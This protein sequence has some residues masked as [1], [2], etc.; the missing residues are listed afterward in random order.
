MPA[1]WRSY[2][3]EEE[4]CDAC[5]DLEELGPGAD[6]ERRD[7]SPRELV[8]AHMEWLIAGAAPDAPRRDS[9]EFDA[10][11]L[12]AVGIFA[13]RVGRVGERRYGLGSRP[14]SRARVLRRARRAGRERKRVF[15]W[16]GRDAPRGAAAAA[17]YKAVELNRYLGGGGG[18]PRAAR[19]EVEG[20]E[21]P[22]FAEA[23]DALGRVVTESD[24]DESDGGDADAPP[25]RL[26]SAEATRAGPRLVDVEPR[27][28]LGAAAAAAAARYY[29]SLYDHGPEPPPPPKRSWFGW[30]ERKRARSGDFGHFADDADGEP[31]KL[32]RVRWLRGGLDV[33]EARGAPKRRD[34]RSDGAAVLLCGAAV[35][36]AAASRAPR[37]AAASRLARELAEDGAVRLQDGVAEGREPLPF[38]SQ[39]ADCLPRTSSLRPSGSRCDIFSVVGGGDGVGVEVETFEQFRERRREKRRRRFEDVRSMLAQSWRIDEA[40]PTAR[41]ASPS[42][43]RG[44]DW[45]E[46]ADAFAVDDAEHHVVV[47]EIDGKRL[48]R[49]DEAMHGHFDAAK[50]YAVLYGAAVDVEAHDARAPPRRAAATAATEPG[51]R[52]RGAL[53]AADGDGESSDGSES[54]SS[55]DLV[56]RRSLRL[57]RSSLRRTPTGATAAGCRF[58]LFFWRG[59]RAPVEDRTRYLMEHR[60]WILEDWREELACAPPPHESH[61]DMREEPRAFLDVVARS[62]GGYVV[63]M[64]GGAD[65]PAHLFQVRGY[66]D[67]GDAV[68]F[69][70]EPAAAL[71]CSADCFA[72][73]AA[74]GSKA[75]FSMA[76]SG[77]ATWSL[78]KAQ[79]TM[80][81]WVGDGS[82]DEVKVIDEAQSENH[83]DFWKCLAGRRTYA[84]HRIHKFG[85]ALPRAFTEAVFFDVRDGGGVARVAG[86]QR[87]LGRSTALVVDARCYVFLWLGADVRK[88]A[89]R[90][91]PVWKSTTATLMTAP[92]ALDDAIVL[93]L[94][95]VFLLLGI[96]CLAS[97]GRRR[98]G[99]AWVKD[100]PFL[101]LMRHYGPGTILD[102]HA[103]Y[104]RECHPRC[105][106]L[107]IPLDPR[108]I[109]TW[110]AAFD[111]L[112]GT[113]I[114]NAD[115]HLWRK[116]RKVS[117]HEFSVKSMRDFMFDIF[118]NHTR[119]IVTLAGDSA[120]AVDAQELFAQYTLQSIGQIGFGVDLGALRG[121]EGAA[122]AADFG[123]AFNAATQLSGDRFVDPLWRLK[124]FFGDTS[125]EFVFTDEEL[126]FAVINFVLAG[127]DTTANQLTWLLYECCRRPEVVAAIRA[128]SD[129]L[130]NRVDYEAALTETLRLYPSVPTDFKTALKDDVL[131]DGTGIRR[132]ERVMFATWAMG[133]MAEYW[134]DPLAFDPGRF[135]DDGKFLFPDACKMPAFLAGPRTCLG[136]DVAYLGTAVLVASL[137]DTFDVAYA[138]D[139]DPVYDTGLTMWAAGPVP[140]AFTPRR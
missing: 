121:P 5:D 82:R 44:V 132:G 20:S 114:F 125:K 56:T 90:R 74:P 89:A 6:D 28:S 140:I 13:W 76:L 22:E 75:G 93:K 81:V 25:P 1:R 45:A 51:R 99:K 9:G 53:F 49:V 31:P 27:A 135:L 91:A 14:A 111:D 97:A 50:S 38:R 52:P 63:H 117:S 61:V 67:A 129:A 109:A 136:K 86:D 3:S 66:G 127:R 104:G 78:P 39:F 36:R 105:W 96:A 48:R 16:L 40:P 11:V 77:G 108:I 118:A 62:M 115:G 112:L 43:D 71:L 8:S 94:A 116:Q 70:V 128:E 33:V 59:E 41:R 106:S 92:G 68:A 2:S 10:H 103:R 21:S 101:E 37:R 32:F 138:G 29:P 134:D 47:W 133:R 54:A 12:T 35:T 15:H 23:A 64:A 87:S 102:Y 107:K 34:L 73:Q 4:S 124:R 122:V 60:S 57:S 65:R 113:G 131:P 30:L 7:P 79:W 83:A 120:G 110:R 130:G 55:S 123:D 98:P 72:L 80:W 17:A 26:L 19:R 24:D 18:G 69:E 85:A 84:D 137:L 42:A 58:F 139:A 95:G 88:K 126:H 119:E 46:A 100:A